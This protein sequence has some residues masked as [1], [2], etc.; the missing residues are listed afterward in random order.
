MIKSY[1]CSSDCLSCPH[2]DPDMTVILPTKSIGT[3]EIAFECVYFIVLFL[4]RD[5]KV[6]CNVFGCHP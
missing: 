6:V 2:N 5:Q 4:P 1:L 3:P